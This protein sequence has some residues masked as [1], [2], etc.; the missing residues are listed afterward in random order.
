MQTLTA[1][2]TCGCE[3][4]ELRFFGLKQGHEQRQQQQQAAAP[5]AIAN[6]WPVLNAWLGFQPGGG[7]GHRS[8][9]LQKLQHT[10]GSLSPSPAMLKE[11]IQQLKW[12]QTL[13][14]STGQLVQPE[15]CSQRATLTALLLYRH[16][17]GK[18]PV[19]MA[20]FCVIIF[21][22]DRPSCESGSA[23]PS[24]IRRNKLQSQLS[25]RS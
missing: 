25:K 8:A 9:Q 15:S 7:H 24:L 23:R 14:A 12:Q 5:P 11:Q 13:V 1:A 19:Q 16:L 10:A 20:P 3:G 21:S 4:T 2:C 6:T 22:G 18:L 17:T